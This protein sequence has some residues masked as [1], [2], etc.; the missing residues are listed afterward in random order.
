MKLS[1]KEWFF[2]IGTVLS[3]GIA[4]GAMAARQ[5]AQDEKIDQ[6]VAVPS[7]LATLTERITSIDKRTTETQQDIREIRTYL[8]PK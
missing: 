6:L 5:S 2:L 8:L 4:W 1:N 7:N 3:G